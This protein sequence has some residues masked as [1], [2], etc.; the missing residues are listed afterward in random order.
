M[1]LQAANAMMLMSLEG[2]LRAVASFC[3]SMRLKCWQGLIKP[4]LVDVH[5]VSIWHCFAN[6]RWLIHV[7]V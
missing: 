1:P 2:V 6:M 4:T 5:V 3:A 7:A